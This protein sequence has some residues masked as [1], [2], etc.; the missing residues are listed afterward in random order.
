MDFNL[1]FLAGMNRQVIR[2]IGQMQANPDRPSIADLA[3]GT[4]DGD[5]GAIAI[6]LVPPKPKYDE[7]LK[8]SLV[9]LV[10]DEPI[11]MEVVQSHLEEVGYRNIIA[12]D[13]ST[14]AIAMAACHQPDVILLDLMMPMV[15]GLDILAMVQNDPVLS[16]I[17]IVVLTSNTDAGTK[18]RALELGVADF[19]QKPVDPSELVLRLR[20]TLSAKA[21]RDH[22]ACYSVTLEQ[23]VRIRTEQL[24]SAHHQIIHC[25]ARAADFRDDDTGK[26]VVR[27]GRYAA[28]IAL[29]MGF[30]SNYV[31]H[32]QI[33]AQLHDIGKIGVPDSILLKPRRLNPN[34]FLVMKE[35]CDI[36][37]AI[38]NC[39]SE[40]HDPCQA[41]TSYR[42][43]S[44]HYG[45]SRY[46]DHEDGFRYRRDASRALGWMRV[47]QRPA[48]RSDSDRGANHGRGRRV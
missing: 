42:D 17:P 36:G 28:A 41:G 20:N 12:T 48:R 14:Q 46:A 45:Y 40:R 15:S 35:H 10:D 18:L 16:H 32:I 39:Q 13:D 44:H 34:E 24:E 26:H 1:Y 4:S 38:I 27:V 6:G 19:L 21:Y 37:T 25:L 22:L 43:R 33:A 23:Q 47:P 29:K 9:M 8:A 31:E 2:E 7:S 3:W 5:P 30:D 11:I